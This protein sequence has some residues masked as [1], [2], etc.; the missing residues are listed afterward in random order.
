MA[1]TYHPVY[2]PRFEVTIGRTKY[3]E[4]TGLIQDLVV[5]NT[6]DGAALCSF[7]LNHTFDQASADFVDLEWNDIEPGTDLK[8]AIGWGGEGTTK[9]M[10]VGTSSSINTEFRMGSGASL[11]VSGYGPLY[12]MM[13]GVVER[14][15]SNETVINVVKKVLGE[16]FRD[17]TVEGKS[18]KRNRIIQHNRNDYRFVSELATEYGFEFYADLDRAYFTPRR[19]ISKK[20]PE[21]TLTWGRT[22]DV[23]DAEITTAG[24]LNTVE[25]RYWDM[26]TEKEIVGTATQ[27]DGKGKEVF[28]IVCDSEAEA[29]DIAESRLSRLS[30]ERANG[31]GETDG[32]PGLTA[33]SVIRLE[34]L[35]PRFTGNYYI[36]RATHR[37]GGSGYRTA[38]GF[39]QLPP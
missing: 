13:R 2:S 19:S 9:P 27:S 5:E 24:Q 12:A 30:M 22:L 25:V 32:I 8:V 23:F 35:G 26:Q 38:F 16:Y 3:Q 31:V 36:T 34:G 14:S 39:T 33:G 15:W 1:T 29:V 10:F 11:S 21:M 17:V 7:T 6:V 18:S 20:T 37:V 4:S 28:R